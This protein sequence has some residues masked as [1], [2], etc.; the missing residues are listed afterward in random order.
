MC[1]IYLALTFVNELQVTDFTWF[2][3]LADAATPM[4]WKRKKRV[5][6]AVCIWILRVWWEKNCTHVIGEV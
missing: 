6:E 4:F 3:K 5:E 1:F 2:N